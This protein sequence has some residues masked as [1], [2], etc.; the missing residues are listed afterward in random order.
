[1]A[2]S[3]ASSSWK[4]DE[5]AYHQ[6]VKASLDC[7]LALHRGSRATL[8]SM[9]WQNC[10]KLQQPDTETRGLPSHPGHNQVTDEVNNIYKWKY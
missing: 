2:L 6:K 3:P 5:E 9:L 10:W 8:A 7:P 1:M 4:G